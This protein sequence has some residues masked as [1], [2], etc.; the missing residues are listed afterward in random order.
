MTALVL[1]VFTG[2]SVIASADD[3][4]P[5]T[6][7][8]VDLLFQTPDGKS[9]QIE[10][11]DISTDIS[12]LDKPT[13]NDIL[14]PYFAPNYVT[15]KSV[16][17]EIGIIFKYANDPTKRDQGIAELSQICDPTSSGGTDS[18][19]FQTRLATDF[20]DLTSIITANQLQNM[21]IDLVKTR[22][23]GHNKAILTKSAGGTYSL[24]NFYIYLKPKPATPTVI[25]QTSFTADQQATVTVGQSV[26]ATTFHAKAT[27]NSGDSIPVTVDTSKADL[28][29]PGTYS[30]TLKAANGETKAVT[31]TVQAAPSPVVPKQTVVYGLKKLYLYQKPT[32]AHDQRLAT[33][34]QTNRTRRPMFKVVG[35]ARS[36]SGLLRYQVKDATGKTGYITAKSAFVAPVY[37]QKSVKRI[38]VLNRQGIDR[39]QDLK[40]SK[41][42]KHVKAGKTLKVVGLKHYRLTT[43]FELSNGQFVSANK[44]L[45]IAVK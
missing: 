3:S 38:K 17:D 11:P 36:K 10:T 16:Y 9:V 28:K 23:E 18:A 5:P 30:V 12:Q 32:F 6:L 31:L 4:T 7:V 2:K 19:E 34:P 27:N 45:V 25:D 39:Y 26:D 37:Y 35:Y 43:R 41:A 14:R 15:G 42:G 22:Q 29:K 1:G 21:T 24:Q 13:M 8:E 40:L 33:Y 20:A 44:K